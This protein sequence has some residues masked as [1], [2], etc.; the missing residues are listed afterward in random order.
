MCNIE[1]LIMDTPPIAKRLKEFFSRYG[2]LVST[3]ADSC[4]IPRP[5]LSQLLNGR[6]KKVSNEVFEKIHAAYPE[7]N[8]TWLIFGEGEMLVPN[9]NLSAAGAAVQVDE[10]TDFEHTS[11][12]DSEDEV[13]RIS[14]VD[15]DEHESHL[16]LSPQRER[17]T[18][19]AEEVALRSAQVAMRQAQSG[20]GTSPAERQLKSV[21][22][23]YVY[24]DGSVTV[25][26]S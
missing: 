16:P 25:T 11:G 22:T 15:S 14:F 2:I 3:F 26:Q 4:N 5:S 10:K 23:I 18:R 9:A 20:G 1:D 8:M 21:I 24:T 12:S 6:N 7:I 17:Q 13:G 19:L